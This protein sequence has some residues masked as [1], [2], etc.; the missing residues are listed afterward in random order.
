MHIVCE[1]SVVPPL[2]RQRYEIVERKGLGHPD[3]ICDSVMDA[4][5]VAL[6]QEYERTAGHILHHNLDKSLLIAGRT[7]K[8]CGG[9]QVIQ[10]MELIMGDRA[11][12]QFKGIP[13]PV[14]DIAIATA[15]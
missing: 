3:T 9:G 13:I 14:Q 8:H 7:V 12:D 1:Q 15:K 6:C 5:S 2:A 4:V 11:T 10:P